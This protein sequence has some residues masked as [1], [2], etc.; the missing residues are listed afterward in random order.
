MRTIRP[1]L[2]VAL[3]LLASWLCLAAAPA[4]AGT[5]VQFDTNLG[6]IEVE[7]SSDPALATTVNNFMN[8]VNTGRYTDTFIH[9]STT[10]NP[11]DIQIIQGG[12]YVLDGSTINEVV[13]DAP[14]L[15]EAVYSNTR[16][17]LAMARSADPN[18][19]TS[20]WFFNVTDNPGLNGNYAV[21]GLITGTASLDVMDAIAG[22][23]VYDASPLLGPTFSELPLLNPALTTNNLVMI[24]SISAVPEPSTYVLAGV[25]LAAAAVTAARRSRRVAA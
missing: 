8:Y 1:T 13:T 22:L 12:S 2:R 5:I 10:Y 3:T 6:Q 21:F 19:A 7:L 18:S 24:N 11:A 20:G 9:R 15:L 16:G 25:G 17:T 14:I 23:T 4:A